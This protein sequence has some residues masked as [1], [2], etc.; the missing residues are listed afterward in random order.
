VILSYSPTSWDVLPLQNGGFSGVKTSC[1]HSRSPIYAPQETD[2]SKDV[3]QVNSAAFKNLLLALF[4]MKGFKFLLRKLY[5]I[6]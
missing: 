1:L 5:F 6:T 2:I 3:L 4:K